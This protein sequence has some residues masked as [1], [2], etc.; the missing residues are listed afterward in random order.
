MVWEPRTNGL[1]AARRAGPTALASLAA[2]LPPRGVRDEGWSRLWPL[3]RRRPASAGL[4]LPGLPDPIP[5]GR[6]RHFP[7]AGVW[8]ARQ[9]PPRNGP[10][11]PPSLDATRTGGLVRRRHLG[12]RPSLL[13]GCEQTQSSRRARAGLGL[14][15]PVPACKDPQ[16]H[17]DPPLAT[18][19][20][21]GGRRRLS[22][23]P[24]GRGLL[25]RAGRPGKAGIGHACHETLVLQ[26]GCGA[27]R[28][29]VRMPRGRN[30]IGKQAVHEK[31]VVA[32]RSRH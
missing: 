21:G 5:A 8:A 27:G 2:R 19:P 20:A 15:G 22:R 16:V 26:L 24:R 13:L 11:I 3:T 9:S 29:D 28:P 12:L 14:A 18:R 6:S 31:G 23:V 17:R 10:I 32:G 30:P 1:V 25:G 7:A 4:P